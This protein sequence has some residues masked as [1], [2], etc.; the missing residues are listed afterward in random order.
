MLRFYGSLSRVLSS[1]SNFYLGYP[2]Q[3]QNVGLRP[4]NIYVL[5]KMPRDRTA[6]AASQRLD[7]ERPPG[8]C[9]G[10]HLMK[11]KTIKKEEKK[12]KDLAKSIAQR[13]FAQKMSA[14]AAAAKSRAKASEKRRAKAIYSNPAGHLVNPRMVSKE[15]SKA[16]F[17]ACVAD[18]VQANACRAPDI[19]TMRETSLVAFSETGT[20]TSS[21]AGEVCF[22]LTTDPRQVF[23]TYAGIA[24][25][26][27]LSVNSATQ[28]VHSYTNWFGLNGLARYGRVVGRKYTLWPTTNALVTSGFYSDA[29]VPNTSVGL[30]TYQTPGTVSTYPNS[31]VGNINPMSTISGFMIPTGQAM[32]VSTPVGV[33]DAEVNR[34]FAYRDL[35]F[36][37]SP[38][39]ND[40]QGNRHIFSA[41]GLAVNTRVFQ[42][43][44]DTV[45]ELQPLNRIIAQFSGSSSARPPP[46]SEESLDDLMTYVRPQVSGSKPVVEGSTLIGQGSS[47]SPSDIVTHLSKPAAE[48]PMSVSDSTES[49]LSTLKPILGTVGEH[50]WN[51]AKEFGPDILSAGLGLIPGGS[52]AG[53]ATKY[54]SRLLSS[55]LS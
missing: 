24:I 38:G 10:I 29:P 51:L 45:Y 25:F 3:D 49:M 40:E 2:V 20:I 26:G 54:G 39:A 4:V 46:D 7:D 1:T 47:V 21:A 12:E 50:A 5:N 42:I 36:S 32:P 44:V 22:A 19:E 13:E 6:P 33:Y 18:P 23:V 30:S 11:M 35:V 27:F 9:P 8:S 41:A 53:V 52:L 34:P 16:R 17:L 55:F 15:L 43:R 31:V 37:W 28:N 14:E 48:D